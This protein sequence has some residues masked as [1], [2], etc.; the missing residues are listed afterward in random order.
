[1]NVKLYLVCIAVTLSPEILFAQ[2][3]SF[4][5]VNTVGREPSIA[6]DG[7]G[8]PRIS[9]FVDQGNTGVIYH[10]KLDLS[11][12]TFQTEAVDSG[13]FEI[14]TDIAVDQND[15]VHITW[16]NH[17]GAGG[18]LRHAQST[19]GGG[20][21]L[22]D[23]LTPVHDGW[24]SSIVIDSQNLPHISYLTECCIGAPGVA[25]AWFNGVSWVTEYI[26]S[27]P[28]LWIFNGTSIAVDNQDNPHITYYN[29][30][31]QDLMYAVKENGTWTFS[32]IDTSG[33]V[34]RYSS[35]RIDDN[36]VPYVCYFQVVSTGIGTV[37]HATLVGGNWVVTIVDTT[38]SSG[39][40][41]ISLELDQFGNRHVTYSDSRVLKYAVLTGGNTEIETVVDLSSSDSIITGCSLSLDVAGNP[42]ISYSV[43]IGSPFLASTVYAT[44]DASQPP[45]VSDIP[46]RTIPM[47][48][49][50]PQLRVDNFVDDPDTPDSSITW[51]VSGNT[52]LSVTWSQVKR[53]YKIRAPMGW[54]GSETL[55]FTAT[56][57]SG[58]SDSDAAIYTVVASK[59]STNSG[60]RGTSGPETTELQS[61]YPNPFN[62]STSIGY[63]L[64]DDTWITLKV[65]NMLGEEIATLVN[66]YQIA[67][68]KSV[69][70]DGRNDR[71]EMVGSGIYV[72]RIIAG[73]FTKTEKMILAR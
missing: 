11:S 62:P 67:G 36:G 7:Q 33:D 28:D 5:Q 72:Y 58:L 56:D 12:Q 3:W 35:L 68:Y 53:A 43:T 2:N 10:A 63:A 14:Q 27:Q 8:V 48:S 30:G 66:E 50:F 71:G 57:P 24:S 52:S 55:T 40:V 19:V 16:H 17:L 42:H 44:K 73:D 59:T 69:Q 37:N 1:M 45:I 4:L 13:G 6:I 54:A 60:L 31:A 23:V 9:Y 46:D 47:G 70:W 26:G 65:Y 39:D 38:A 64:S 51:S 61:N 21:I 15:D 41:E 18:D 20:W 29:D 34:G 32:T 25:Y 22:E 49:R